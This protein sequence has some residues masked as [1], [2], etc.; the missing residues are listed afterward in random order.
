ML[1]GLISAFSGLAKST[2][3]ILSK[4]KNEKPKNFAELNIKTKGCAKRSAMVNECEL[5]VK[6]DMTR[7]VL[8]NKKNKKAMHANIMYKINSFYI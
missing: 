8:Q 2:K 4:H 1:A 7:R 3:F 6:W 5:S